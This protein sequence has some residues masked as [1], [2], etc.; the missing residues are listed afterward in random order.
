MIPAQNT[1]FAWLYMDFRVGSLQK[2]SSRHKAAL[3]N[4]HQG[5]LI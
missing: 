2:V 5:T 1:T 4:S 3:E